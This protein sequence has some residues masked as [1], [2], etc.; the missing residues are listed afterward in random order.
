MTKSC[1]KKN[2]CLSWINIVSYIYTSLRVE[3]SCGKMNTMLQSICKGVSLLLLRF[4]SFITWVINECLAL[5]LIDSLSHCDRMSESLVL[6]QPSPN[7]TFHWVLQL[8]PFCWWMVCL[9]DNILLAIFSPLPLAEACYFSRSQCVQM[10]PFVQIDMYLNVEQLLLGTTIHWPRIR[11]NI[12][13]LVPS[14]IFLHQCVK[15]AYPLSTFT[16]KR[17]I[18][19]V[20]V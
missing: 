2:G 11:L 10:S 4:V 6:C 15:Q 17:A 5:Y 12:D 13:R 14:A 18:G 3:T 1:E 9:C 7:I 19:D 8:S 20:L 16:Q